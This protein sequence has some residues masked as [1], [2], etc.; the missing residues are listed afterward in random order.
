MT[1]QCSTR[2]PEKMASLKGEQTVF[3]PQILNSLYHN[4]LI[5]SDQITDYE[6]KYYDIT[7]LQFICSERKKPHTIRADKKNRWHAGRD[8]HFKIWQGVPYHSD[9]FQF[10]PVVKC[11]STQKITIRWQFKGN[12]KVVDVNIWNDPKGK[13]KSYGY[14]KWIND[15][16]VQQSYMVEQLAINDG[17]RSVE[18][19]FRWFNEDFTGK[20]IHWTDLR[21]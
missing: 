10:A 5:T 1:I 2:W 4:G 9:T 8:I 6:C 17:F 14:V 15:E 13:V 20:L 11:I 18:H 21:Y 3:V 16:I 19:F 12:E 7:D